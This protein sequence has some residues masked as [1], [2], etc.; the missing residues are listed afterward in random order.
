MA[1][2]M[3]FEPRDNC[4]FG[5]TYTLLE[6][7]DSTNNYVKV[8]S[9]ILPHGH[10]VIAKMQHAGRG[11]QGKSFYSPQNNGLYI[12]FLLKDKRV[13]EGSLFTAKICVAVCRA[14]DALTGTTNANGVGIK[15]VNDIYFGGKK[16][17][18]ILCERFINR[19]AESCIV[20]GIGVNLKIDASSLPTELSDIATSLYDIT[21]KEYSS[22]ALAKLICRE[23]DNVFGEDADNDSLLDE[24]KKRSVVIGREI[25]ILS[26]QGE[27]R[28]AALDICKNGAL[29]VRTEDGCTRELSGGEISVRLKKKR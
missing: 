27:T 25:T 13:L 26:E 7:V 4:V 2:N 12:S 6:S 28:A 21:G 9:N 29:L 8:L 24:Y 10:A 14:I 15:W 16:L 5:E 22:A 11:R 17:C 1:E 23:L 20:A 18:G 3:I 19:D